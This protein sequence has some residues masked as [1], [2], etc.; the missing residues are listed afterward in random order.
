MDLEAASIPYFLR[1][2]EKGPGNEAMD[3]NPGMR[4]LLLPFDLLLLLS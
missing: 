2:K 3:R 1:K 4:I